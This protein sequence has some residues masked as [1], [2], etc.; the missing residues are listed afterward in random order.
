MEGRRIFQIWTSPSPGPI[1]GNTAPSLK[2][3]S[4][5]AVAPRLAH[6]LVYIHKYTQGGAPG[7]PSVTRSIYKLHPLLIY[8]NIAHFQVFFRVSAADEIGVLH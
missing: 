5:D 6:P 8:T 7:R 3:H 4:Y 2:N 1:T